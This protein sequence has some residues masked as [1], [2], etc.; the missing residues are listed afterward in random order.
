MYLKLEVQKRQNYRYIGIGIGVIKVVLLMSGC[1]PSRIHYCGIYSPWLLE[2]TFKGSV[3][4]KY[5]Y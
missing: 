5:I 4:A 2:L 1:A 3:I